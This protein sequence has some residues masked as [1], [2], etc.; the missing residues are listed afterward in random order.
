MVGSGGAAAVTFGT[1]R[2]PICDGKTG[3]MWGMAKQST[4]EWIREWIG[5]IAF[6]VFLWANRMTFDEYHAELME[7]DRREYESEKRNGYLR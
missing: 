7:E 1:L 2:R 3:I 4:L 6:N 5:G